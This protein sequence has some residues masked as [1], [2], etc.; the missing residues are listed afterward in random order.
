MGICS[1]AIDGSLVVVFVRWLCPFVLSPIRHGKDYKPECRAR[2]R[3]TVR[4]L[5]VQAPVDTTANLRSTSFRR[6]TTLVVFIVVE[7]MNAFVLWAYHDR[8]WYPVDE[9]VSGE[10]KF[11]CSKSHKTGEMPTAASKSP[12]V[13]REALSF[14]LMA[15]AAVTALLMTVASDQGYGALLRSD[16]QHF[17][18]VAL[19]PF[20]DGRIFAGSD[21]GAGTAYRYGRLLFPLAAWVL[22]LGHRPLIPVTLPLAYIIG[23]LLFATL[24]CARCARA[25]QPPFVGRAALMVPS[26]FLTV[27]L[28]VPEFL[29]AGLVLLTYHFAETN[30]IRQALVAAA[31]VLLARETAVLALSP[32]ILSHARRR[33]WR[34]L[35]RWSVV[36]IPLMFWYAW[37]RARIGVGRFFD[38]GH[39]A[40]RAL[41]LP[42]RGFLSA[43]WRADAGPALVFAASLGWITIA[44]GAAVVWWRRTP[45][46]WAGLSMASLILV[47][48]LGEAELPGEAVRLMLPAQLLIAV[49]ALAID[50]PS[51]RNARLRHKEGSARE[52]A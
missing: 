42:M 34:A 5:L 15:A 45:V 31:L 6:R 3:L 20:G 7:S 46:A 12:L 17:Y 36:V 18:R 49:A 8:Y 43:V 52:G 26:A 13:T 47:F 32:L 30:R 23:V 28:L 35:L 37:V 40:G 21:E 51:P 10:W 19:D 39:P 1:R 41:D 25:G 44:I 9:G 4:R 29:I 22:A 16:A 50:H 24:A 11:I 2:R 33:E 27:P 38:P 14:G 48:G